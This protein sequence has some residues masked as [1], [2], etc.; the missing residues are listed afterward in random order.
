MGSPSGKVYPRPRGRTRCA[1]C[2]RAAA[3]GLSPPTRGN[4][5]HPC[6]RTA[7]TGSIPAHAGEPR[8]KARRTFTTGV[9]PR[10]RGGT[11]FKRVVRSDAPGLSPPTRGNPGRFVRGTAFTRSIPAHS[12]EPSCVQPS[13]LNVTVYPRPRGGTGLG[14]LDRSAAKGLSPPTRGNLPE[15][16]LFEPLVRSIPAHAGEPRDNVGR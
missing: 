11:A 15:A 7:E 8:G 1:Q 13:R 10:P 2:L 4:R 3:C 6:G 12:G 14:P 16:P 5:L 9:Y